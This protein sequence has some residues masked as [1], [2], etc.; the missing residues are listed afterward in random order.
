[1]PFTFTSLP[2]PRVP[3]NHIIALALTTGSSRVVIE[4]RIV[5]E[6]DIVHGIKAMAVTVRLAFLRER[7]SHIAIR[8]DIISHWSLEI[9]R[10]GAI[11]SVHIRVILQVCRLRG[12]LRMNVPLTSLHLRESRVVASVTTHGIVVVIMPTLLLLLLHMMR[13]MPLLL[14]L[15]LRLWELMLGLGLTV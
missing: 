11:W 14:Q 9:G 1:M 6:L 12:I 7:R 13:E 2:T 5:L 3:F 8:I 10:H 15:L 4:L